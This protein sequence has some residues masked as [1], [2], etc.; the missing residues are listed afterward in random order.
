MRTVAATAAEIAYTEAV[1]T[2]TRQQDVVDGLR[3]RAG[4]LF[5]G[6]ALVT[7]FLGGQALSRDPTFDVVTWIAIGAF[8][9]LF[10]L[11]LVIL[12]PWPFRFA[13]SAQILI[14]DHLEKDVAELQVYVAEIWEKNYHLNQPRVDA[15]HWVFRAACAALSLE[16][17]AW[18][19]SIGRG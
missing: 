10:A 8:V 13:L 6:A 7:A 12:W 2:I 15:L 11:T 4:T 9:A 14:E 18:L 17:V 5:A 1:R 19:I 3:T 16:V